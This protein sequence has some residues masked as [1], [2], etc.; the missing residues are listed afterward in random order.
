MQVDTR[1]PESGSVQELSRASFGGP[2]LH[3]AAA[4][5]AVATLPPSYQAAAML[6]TYDQAEATKDGESKYKERAL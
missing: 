1:A 3:H 5:V 6:P 2:V 4:P